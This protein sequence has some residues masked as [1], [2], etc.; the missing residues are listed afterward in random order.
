MRSVPSGS[1]N[2]IVFPQDSGRAELGPAGSW[3]SGA[4]GELEG[5]TWLFATHPLQGHLHPTA[6][7]GLGTGF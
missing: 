5:S 1:G 7:L 2:N 3:D 6:F 4:V